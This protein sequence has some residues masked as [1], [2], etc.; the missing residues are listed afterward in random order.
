MTLAA[1][2]AAGG[3]AGRGKIEVHPEAAVVQV[4]KDAVAQLDASGQLVAQNPRSKADFELYVPTQ[5]GLDRVVARISLDLLRQAQLTSKQTYRNVSSSFRSYQFMNGTV[6]VL[7]VVGFGA[8]MLRGFTS[9]DTTDAVVTAAF[10]GL[11]A[12]S[13]IAFFLSRPLD[14]VATSGPHNA[15]L[16]AIVS[17]YWTKLAY[18]TDPRTA[19]R[20]IDAAEQAMSRAMVTYLQHTQP[21]ATGRR[22]RPRARAPEAPAPAPEQEVAPRPGQRQGAGTADGS[23]PPPSSN[24]A[25]RMTSPRGGDTPG[26]A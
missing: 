10:G 15:W 16:L 12:A 20:D 19:V 6:F 14:A 11:S 25:H 5:D 13:F 22:R 4:R 1:P 23:A 8:A 24:G 21:V 3:A 7:G 17:T 9:Q 26:E 2:E 18:F